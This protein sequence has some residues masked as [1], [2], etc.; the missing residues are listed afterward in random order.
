[1]LTSDKYLPYMKQSQTNLA[2]SQRSHTLDYD[3]SYRYVNL[4]ALIH[5]A[6]HH[7]KFNDDIDN[8]EEEEL[9][10]DELRLRIKTRKDKERSKRSDLTMVKIAALDTAKTV[11]GL[12]R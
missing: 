9:T 11:E 6:G 5:S 4:E 8:S 10:D 1:M 7:F 2:E 3:D 12:R